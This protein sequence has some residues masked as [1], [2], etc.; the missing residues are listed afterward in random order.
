M[1]DYQKVRDLLDGKIGP[2][3]VLS[4]PNLTVE[5]RATI[6][7]IVQ[8]KK[9]GMSPGELKEWILSVVKSPVLDRSDIEIINMLNKI[10]DELK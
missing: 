2:G 8:G 1:L 10:S 5:E 3:S 4:D 6:N 9:L 7:L